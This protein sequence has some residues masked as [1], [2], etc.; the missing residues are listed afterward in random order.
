M[1]KQDFAFAGLLLVIILT[2]L[3]FDFLADY[4]K[5]FLFN[6]KY[7]AATSFLK[8]A[9]LATLGECIGLRIT[10]GIYSYKGFGLIP[11]AIVWGILGVGIQIAFVVFSVGSPVVLE[12]FV[13]VNNSIASMQQTDI[14][15]A[16]ENNL[17]VERLLSAFSISILLNLIFAPV[18]MT[19]HKIT[20]THIINN[21]GTVSGFLSPIKYK[22]IFPALNWK[23]QW[24][25]VFKKTIPFFWI[26]MHTITFL[27]PGEYRIVFAAVLGVALGIILAIANLKK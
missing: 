17:G 11:R 13:G 16:F 20:D 10:K 6:S 2:F 5:D 3:P 14:L 7:W 12:K 21:G 9:I 8:F 4:H 27:L 18:F 22:E 26:P 23:V 1:K 15:A 19:L 25:F 24:N